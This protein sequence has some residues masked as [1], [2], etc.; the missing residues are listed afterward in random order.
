MIPLGPALIGCIW[1]ILHV[2][3]LEITEEVC[4][5]SKSWH[6]ASCLTDINFSDMLFVC[7]C[8]WERERGVCVLHASWKRTDAYAWYTWDFVLCNSMWRHCHSLSFYL[9][10]AIPPPRNWSINVIVPLV[11]IRSLYWLVLLELPQNFFFLTG[12][13]GEFYS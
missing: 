1:K 11:L 5:W 13:E 9:S 4:K 7:T 2:V 6:V 10:F 8:A 3:W 12:G